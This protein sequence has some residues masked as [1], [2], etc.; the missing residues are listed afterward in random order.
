MATQHAYKGNI[1][2][3]FD[4][5][6]NV[7][8]SVERLQ[9]ESERI[10]YLIIENM[11]ENVNILPV[12]YIS[13]NVS[14]D[15]YSKIVNSNETSKFYLLIK[16]KDGL[17]QNSIFNKIIE[18]KFT[19]V[20]SSTN[21]NY[22]ETLDAN[23]VD[24]Y[25]GITIGLV[26]DKMTNELRKS[27]NGVYQNIDQNTLVKL[28]T[29]D[30]NKQVIAPLKYNKHYKEFVIPP[31]ASRYRLLN[32]IFDHD[33]FYDSVF[34][35]FMDFNRT[36]LIP[37]NGKAIDSKDGKPNNIIIN[38]KNYT[39]QEAFDDGYTIENNAYVLYIN[40]ASTNMIINNATSKVTNNI[41]GYWDSY[42]STQN[43]NI[44][45]NNT[46]ENTTKTMFIRSNNAAGLRNQIESESV[47]LEL[48]KQNLDGDIFEPNRSYNVSNYGK[49]TKYNG[50][51]YLVYKR[52][53]YTPNSGKEFTISTNVGLKKAAVE[54][55]A[56][57]I[58][59]EL[60]RTTLAAT[61]TGVTKS[62]ATKKTTNKS[63]SASRKR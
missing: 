16:K 15:M 17:S 19:Y 49:Y 35:F 28:A 10:K 18:D 25:K 48:L 14:S 9:I 22:S 8:S 36:Y 59:N 2:L 62:T 20:V 57:S 44:D 37:R 50:A 29:K 60:R 46:A 32:F 1:T 41:V 13:I 54:E 63:V 58:S 38:V 30:L 47:V 11:Y 43:L 5:K 6:A 7:N 12:I 31:I 34:T 40:G 21:A 24:A 23:A 56:R 51:Y 55:T 39:A 27:F 52:E 4:Y 42:S 3:A 45:N 26:S 53:I 61:S 33:P